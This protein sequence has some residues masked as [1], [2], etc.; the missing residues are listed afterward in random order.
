M[1]DALGRVLSRTLPEGQQESMVY[2]A[3]GNLIQ[4]TDFKGQVSTYNY[5]V[6]DRLTQV[7]YEGGLSETY[8]YDAVGNRVQASKTENGVTSSWVYRYDTL[9][10]LISETQFTG[11]AQEVTLSYEYDA[12]GNRTTLTETTASSVRVTRYTF[13]ALNRLK[14]VQD[15]DA[16]I[17]TYSYDAVGNQVGM[18][19]QNSIQTTY[20]YD[21]LNRLTGLNHRDASNTILKSFDYTL[22]ANGKRA[23]IEEADGRIS[24]YTYDSLY[25]LTQEA[26]FDP[27]N[28]SHNASYSYDM[29]GNR[30]VEVVNGVTTQ[31]TYNDND[32]LVQTGGITYTYNENGST[33]TETLDSNVT[34]YTYNAKNELIGQNQNSEDTVYLYNTDGIRIGQASSQGQTLYTL[35]NNRSYAQ[36]ITEQR[37]GSEAVSYT[38]GDDLVS[39]KRGTEV[40][41]YHY[42]GLGSTRV[43]SD[44]AGS[45]SDEYD[46]DAFGEILNQLG[47]T[48]NNY[49]FTGEQFDSN[50]DQYYLRARYYNQNVGRFTQMDTF[51]GRSEDPVTLHK[52]LYANADPVNGIDPSGLVTLLEQSTVNR[53]IGT[54]ASGS[55]VRSLPISRVAANDAILATGVNAS[56]REVGLLILAGL[57]ASGAKLFDLLT[58]KEEDDDRQRLVDYYRATETGETLDILECNCFRFLDRGFGVEPTAVKRFFLNQGSAIRFGNDF[59]LSNFAGA[60]DDSFFIVNAKVSRAFDAVVTSISGGDNPGDAFIGAGRA[61]PLVLLPALNAEVVRNGGIR[62]VGEHR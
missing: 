52:Y 18:V 47:S 36:V 32:W 30:I 11:T 61:V 21:E 58:D 3:I 44:S 4:R 2:D 22:L 49:L 12:Q 59:L 7:I 46:Y 10:R 29:V 53:T 1:Y 17:T 41:T 62:I 60:N 50:L 6:N 14:T 23:K 24:D 54:Q 57:G 9:N 48:E 20:V 35:D 39:Q 43:L 28:T 25:R 38:Y 31:Y 16:N 34:S 45:I 40:S 55:I 19:H 27:E 26:V 56:S 8:A 42:D 13:D 51:M 5:D 37:D 15:P 33:L